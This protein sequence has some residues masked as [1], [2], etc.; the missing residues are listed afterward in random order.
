MQLSRE[1]S[2]SHDHALGRDK[3]EILNLGLEVPGTFLPWHLQFPLL[4]LL[5]PRCPHGD[6]PH[7]S[8][9]FTQ[10]LPS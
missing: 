8:Q 4:G 7:H 1:E 5:V 3:L 6:C 10:A 2:G 9:A